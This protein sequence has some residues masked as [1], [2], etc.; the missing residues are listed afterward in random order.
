MLDAGLEG[1]RLSQLEELPDAV[2]P[3]ESALVSITDGKTRSG[4][5]NSFTLA[6]RRL[7]VA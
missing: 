5:S 6:W 3:A 4:F 7:M 2:G 1:D